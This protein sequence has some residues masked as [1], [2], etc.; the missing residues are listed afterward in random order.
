MQYVLCGKTMTVK[1]HTQ[2]QRKVKLQSRTKLQQRFAKLTKHHSQGP[3]TTIRHGS[4]T[5]TCSTRV[6]P[7]IT[8]GKC[9]NLVLSFS[10]SPGYFTV[11]VKQIRHAVCST[12]CESD[13]LIRALDDVFSFVHDCSSRLCPDLHVGGCDTGGI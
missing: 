5:I 1:V 13:G 4:P 10:P 12:A 3:G 6:G 7:S 11:V 8:C 2:L 9:G